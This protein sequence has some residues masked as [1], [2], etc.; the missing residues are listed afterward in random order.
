M[1]EK[2]VQKIKIQLL[3][4]MSFQPINPKPYLQSLVGKPVVIKLKFNNIEYHGKLLSIDNYMNLLLDKDVKEIDTAAETSTD[5][6]DELFVRC[7]NV[8]W[9]GE[10]Q[11]NEQPE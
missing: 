1:A 10:K 7:N 6:G 5:L 4:T 11:D 2:S 3:C 8:L 9:V